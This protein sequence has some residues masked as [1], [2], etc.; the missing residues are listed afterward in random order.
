[1]GG[2]EAV[3]TL[4]RMDPQVKAIVCSGYCTDPVMANHREHGFSAVL[5]KPYRPHDLS[6][7][8]KELLGGE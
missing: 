5:C 3:Q 1:V 2:K 8:L 7:V 4:L 6:K